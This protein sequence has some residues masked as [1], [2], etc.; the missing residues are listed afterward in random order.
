MGIPCLAID[1]Q[2][3]VMQAIAHVPALDGMRS[4]FGLP[5]IPQSRRNACFGVA[6][7]LGDIG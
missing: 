2:A 4:K 3:V 5:K 6:C 1:A 7:R